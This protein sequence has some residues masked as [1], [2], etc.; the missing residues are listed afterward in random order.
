MALSRQSP[1]KAT[2]NSSFVFLMIVNY[3]ST[4]HF[5]SQIHMSF[6]VA[7][8]QHNTTK[9]PT[10]HRTCFPCLLLFILASLFIFSQFFYCLL[11]PN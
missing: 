2:I 8:Q 9:K 11:R 4:I 5:K 6:V 10:L 1:C 7:Q 3:I